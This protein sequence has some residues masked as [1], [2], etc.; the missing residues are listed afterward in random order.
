MIYFA[1]L[2]HILCLFAGVDMLM[3]A[4]GK[5]CTSLF[6]IL[7]LLFFLH[8]CSK[9]LV[10]C[11][12]LT[13]QHNSFHAS[14]CGTKRHGIETRHYVLSH[15]HY[16]AFAALSHQSLPYLINLLVIDLLMILI[17]SCLIIVIVDC[18]EV[19]NS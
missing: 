17:I 18:A 5:D 11:C 10:A 9:Y 8:C 2:H 12:G 14:W 6:S 15:D 3:K 1:T 13:L 7:L 4:A 16:D 19:Y